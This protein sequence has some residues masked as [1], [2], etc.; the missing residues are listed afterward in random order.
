M[1]TWI[2]ITLQVRL[3]HG[4]DVYLLF[5]IFQFSQGRY[6]S[7]LCCCCFFVL[8][9]FFVFKDSWLSI[10]FYIKKVKSCP[11]SLWTFELGETGAI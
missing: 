6:F 2:P 1:L 10:P 11:K 9:V 4:Y 5:H 7:F 8:F 3:C